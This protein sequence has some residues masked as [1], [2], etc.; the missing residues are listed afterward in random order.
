MAYADVPFEELLDI[1]KQF[2]YTHGFLATDFDLASWAAPEP[3]AQARE[4][5]ASERNV[6]S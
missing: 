5:L 2:L 1:Q 6:A 3:L 4:L